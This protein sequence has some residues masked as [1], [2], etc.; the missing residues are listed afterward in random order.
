MNKQF[1]SNVYKSK[2][3]QPKSNGLVTV[4]TLAEIMRKNEN[5]KEHIK[6]VIEKKGQVAK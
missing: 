6:R 5:R 3:N 2:S 4:P 1:T